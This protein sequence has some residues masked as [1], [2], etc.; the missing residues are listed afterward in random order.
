M[1]SAQLPGIEAQDNVGRQARRPYGRS[2]PE[3]YETLWGAGLLMTAL[4]C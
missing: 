4:A 2:T 1:T 3:A